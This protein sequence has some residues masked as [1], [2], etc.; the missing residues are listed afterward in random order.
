MLE[1]TF[2]KRRQVR[3][4]DKNNI[5]E[6]SLVYNLIKKTLGL[7]PSKQNLIPYK[8]HILGPSKTTIKKNLYEL[9]SKQELPNNYEQRLENLEYGNTALFAPY[10][11]LFEKRLPETNKWVEYLIKERGHVFEQCDP[12]L[13]FYSTN[14]TAIEIGLFS[15]I[16]TGLCLENNIS[17]SYTQCFPNVV[18]EINNLNETVKKNPYKGIVDFIE[19]DIFLALSLGFEDNN[20]PEKERL[21]RFSK[22]GETK[23]T[24]DK[25]IEWHD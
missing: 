1:K 25:I 17:I 21:A 15:A 10:V 23:P 7:V 14:I 9:A 6:D 16:F 2:R 20:K 22:I 12:D 13:H 3:Y 24:I 11:L 4:F 5:P 19:E 8:I 18:R